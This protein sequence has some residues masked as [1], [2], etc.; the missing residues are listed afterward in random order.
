MSRLLAASLTALALG[1]ALPLLTSAQI[2][3]PQ[4][5]PGEW[6]MAMNMGGMAMTVQTCMDESMESRAAL[7]RAPAG[8]DRAQRNCSQ[9]EV[10][11]LPDG[12]MAEATCT[13]NGKTSHM[14]MVLTGDFQTSYTMDM[15]MTPEGGAETKIK[16]S[17][18]W[19]G[20]CPAGMKPGQS[21]MDMSGMGGNIAA[22]IAAAQARRGE[23]AAGAGQ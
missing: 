4:I 19:V 3:P 18:H 5:K 2:A 9:Q 1:A 10:K 11:Q 21:K 16:V 12:Y 6:D 22:A 17:S 8:M 7:L 15:T 20:A 23:A 13:T 14:K